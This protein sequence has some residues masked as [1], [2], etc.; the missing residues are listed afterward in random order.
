MMW[1]YTDTHGVRWCETLTIGAGLAIAIRTA[2]PA[3]RPRLFRYAVT[4]R[5]YRQ[6]RWTCRS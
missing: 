5:G 4:P 1:V 3:P 6:H 2:L